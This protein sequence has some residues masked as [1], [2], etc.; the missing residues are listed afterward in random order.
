MCQTQD[1]NYTVVNSS[2]LQKLG[3]NAS[4]MSELLLFDNLD[5]TNADIDYQFIYSQSLIKLG[6]NIIIICGSGSLTYMMDC[7]RPINLLSGE[8]AILKEGEIVEFIEA[9]LQSKLILISLPHTIGPLSINEIAAGFS[10]ATL[11]PSADIFEEICCIYRYMKAKMTDTG[12]T[13]RE[14]ILHVY[15]MAILSILSDVMS[16]DSQYANP[17][18]SNRQRELYNKFVK[19]VKDNYQTHRDV[20]FYASE[21]CVTPGHL[22]RIVRSVS[23]KAVSDWIKDYV[24]L[25]AKAMMQLRDLPI[26]EVSERLGFPNPS[27][28]SKFFRQREGLT[29]SQ[30]RDSLR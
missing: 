9:D 16:K 24:V 14:E 8:V 27:F 6:S 19:S 10:S 21:V 20:G 26:A 1:T 25:E 22:G 2:L 4:E 29:P 18:K 5:G 23:G 12:F 28:F 7:N 17:P 13:R 15:L 11:T 3:A 30:Y